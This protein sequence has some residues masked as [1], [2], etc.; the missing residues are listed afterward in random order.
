[1]D[2]ISSLLK[3]LEYQR[4]QSTGQVNK[5]TAKGNAKTVAAGVHLTGSTA[6]TLEEVKLS[7]KEQLKKMDKKDPDFSGKAFRIF[8]HNILAWK[9]GSEILNDTTFNEIAYDVEHLM[10]QDANLKSQFEAM[11]NELV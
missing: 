11:L 10:L 4:Q 3:L 9:L 1:M 5:D 2:P 8:V 6:A 7:V